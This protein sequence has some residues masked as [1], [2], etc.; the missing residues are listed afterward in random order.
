MSRI[1]EAHDV[2]R[3][4]INESAWSMMP[5]RENGPADAY[6]H[7]LLAAELTR[8][9]GE[10]EARCILEKHEW[11]GWWEGQ[12]P[13][14][15]AMDRAN[16]EIGIE[17]GR[18][19][20]SWDEVVTEARTKIDPEDPFGDNG[21]ARWL[22]E[23]YW[24]KNP[25]DDAKKEIPTRDSYGDFDSRLNWPGPSSPWE[26]VFPAGP[27]LPLPDGLGPIPLGNCDDNYDPG[28]GA[29]SF[30]PPVDTRRGFEDACE[31]L[32]APPRRDPL[33]VDLNGDGVTT[34]NLR[35]GTFFDQDGNG[36]AEFT[37]WVDPYDGFLV[38]DRNGNGTIDNGTE[39]FGDQTIL[40]TGAKASNGFEALAEWDDNHDGKIDASDTVYSQLRV[41]QDADG[42]GYSTPDELYDLSELN[43]K[44]IGVNS[45][46]VNAADASGNTLTRIGTVEWTDGTSGQIAEYDLQC[47]TMY[48]IASEWLEV[49]DDIAALPDVQ[50]YGVVHD[51]HQAMVRD[52][53]GQLRN[54]VEQFATAT[55]PEAW[56]S[57]NEQ[58]LFKWTGSE[59][60]DP[61]SR[62]PNI[63]ARKLNVLEKIFGQSFLGTTGS[64]PTDHASVLLNESYRQVFEMTR[65]QLMAQSYLK[66]LYD[67]LVYNWDQEK[68]ELKTDFT[69]VIPELV[70][71]LN[72]DPVQGKQ[73][74]S[75][76]ARSLR[77]ISSCSP[78]C[79]LTFR[80]HMLE[81]DPS[82]DWVFD[83]GGLEV[84]DQLGQGDGWYYPHMFGTW[85]SDAVKG[86]LTAGDGVINGLSGDDVIY[87]TARNE[88]I[89]HSDG[90]ALIV[91]G[92]GRD[93]I[94]AGAG[95]DIL[96][97]GEGSDTL[98]GETGNDTYI[99]RVGSGRDSVIETDRTEGNVDAASARWRH[100][101]PFRH[102]S[103][104]K[105]SIPALP[106]NAA[107]RSG[108]CAARFLS[109]CRVGTGGPSRGAFRRSG[110]RL[111][112][113]EPG[114]PVPN[115]PDGRFSLAEKFLEPISLVP[116]LSNRGSLG[117][118]LL[119]AQ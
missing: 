50:G 2:A 30:G 86:S 36:F 112:D 16:N 3:M 61:T 102:A 7:I 84:Y 49:P 66:G 37:A 27:Y 74:L 17:I 41:W 113:P 68:Q 106:A 20:Q 60:I 100:R 18:N 58:I 59:A 92:A 72:Q 19:A 114:G 108:I 4:A 56:D 78:G 44:A 67:K 99:L 73:L 82:L 107:R 98:R 11:E 88:L 83:T 43:I 62:G 109:R 81:I 101:A 53:T 35:T 87:G 25:K 97:G 21:G 64:N 54:L 5:G 31:D 9:F 46:V 96:D 71:A 34:T 48:S 15:E 70:A 90:D 14:S 42:D 75:E 22:P 12:S 94:W 8:R 52:T 77:G 24:Q 6:R 85:G 103:R 63:D 79:Y 65:A 29:C 115:Q 57:L 89:Y 26:P 118:V 80:E 23:D 1:K 51:L 10:F 119:H 32:I 91:A 47:D 95:N 69:S 28:L 117:R 45:T 55:D 33:I 105:H 38:M 40:K 76:F 104:G 13:E 110:A 39:L 116:F 93:T 111:H